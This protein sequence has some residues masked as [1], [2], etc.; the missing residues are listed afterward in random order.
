MPFFDVKESDLR[1]G[2]IQNMKDFILE[3]GKDFTFIDEEY[4][5][6]VG[7]E[8][9]RIYLL[10][11]HRGLQCLVA[12]ELKIG[13]FKP[14]Y[15]SKMDFYL[16]ALDR[17]KKENENPSVGMILCA[18]KDDEVVEYAMSRTLSP[19]MVAEYKL[20]LPDKAVLQKKLQ[21]LINMPLIE[22]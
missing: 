3:V 14:E 20:Q 18:S 9:F 17:Q 22:E 4:R 8:D 11:F 12:F 15:I 16:E 1:K 2:L 10:F 5:V 21:E 6:Q 13:K 19:M 7:G